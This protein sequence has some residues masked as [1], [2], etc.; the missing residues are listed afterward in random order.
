MYIDGVF[1]EIDSFRWRLFPK[2]LSEHDVQSGIQNGIPMD[3]E[4]PTV[5]RVYRGPSSCF[6]V[7]TSEFAIT[8]KAKDLTV[9]KSGRFLFLSGSIERRSISTK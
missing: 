6:Q 3:Q 2:N 7:A 9:N 4:V 8:I 5:L 1:I